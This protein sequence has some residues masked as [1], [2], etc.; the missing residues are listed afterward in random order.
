VLQRTCT[1]GSNHRGYTTV[2]RISYVSGTASFTGR[3]FGLTRPSWPV[4]CIDQWS[5]PKPKAKGAN[6]PTV[7]GVQCD[8]ASAGSPNIDWRARSNFVRSGQPN[9]V[10]V[11]CSYISTP[12]RWLEVW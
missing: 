4:R 12:F 2:L 11:A 1:E 3:W 7:K 9:R 6:E 10:P 8:C 5:S